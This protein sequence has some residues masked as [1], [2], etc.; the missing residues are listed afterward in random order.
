M[1]LFWDIILCC[2]IG[3]TVAMAW[4]KHELLLDAAV[5]VRNFIICACAVPKMTLKTGPAKTGLA[6]TGQAGPLATAMQLQQK[7][8]IARCAAVLSLSFL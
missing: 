5:Q 8:N 2:G 3:D 7:P 4:Y 6:K 1:W